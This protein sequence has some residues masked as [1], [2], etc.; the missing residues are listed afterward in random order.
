[1]S[2][3]KEEKKGLV[4]KIKTMLSTE[5]KEVE[6]KEIEIEAKTTEQNEDL[7]AIRESI[8]AMSEA[9]ATLSER[10]DSK[11]GTKE[12]KSE[13]INLGEIMEVNKWS[14]DVDQDDFELGTI[15]T[16]SYTNFEDE[17]IEN[18]LSSGEY[19][20]KDKRVIQVDSDGKIVL[21][22]GKAGEETETE[23][24]T[25]TEE[26]EKEVEVEASEEKEAEP[27]E[28]DKIAVLMEMMVE[29]KEQINAISNEPNSDPILAK[30]TELSETSSY[31][32]KMQAQ[33]EKRRENK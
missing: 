10:V 8:V 24:E 4:E 3:T 5:T 9:I 28:S 20:L 18:T 26:T 30:K 29:M 16:T 6:T 33:L 15:I 32:S 11:E 2:E 19:E 7:T 1:M 23:T 14:I 13:V 12:E 31:A 25:E 21:I 17:I 22:D 27:K